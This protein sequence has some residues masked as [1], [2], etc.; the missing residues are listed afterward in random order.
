MFNNRIPYSPQMIATITRHQVGTVEKALKIL[1]DMELIEVLDSGAIYML[2]IQQFIGKS[3]T[4]ADRKRE[5]RNR[6]DHEK[7]VFIEQKTEE[8]T[9]VGQ[10]SDKNPPEIEIELEIEREIEIHNKKKN[11]KE[12]TFASLVDSYTS[13]PELKS[14]LKEF[15]KMRNKMKG[16]TI[17]ALELGLANLDK[18][19]VNDETKIAIVNRSTEHSWKGF[20]ALPSNNSTKDF[21]TR[22]DDPF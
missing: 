3:S 16:Y 21:L 7:N 10:M 5:Y 20:F 14:A 22:E 13:N 12:K 15:V 8:K 11:K 6:I 1:Q 9:N 19:A 2:N 18:L 17:R 4:E